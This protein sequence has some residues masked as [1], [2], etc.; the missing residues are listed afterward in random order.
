MTIR[1]F[2]NFYALPR[3]FSGFCRRYARSFISLDG[4]GTRDVPERDSSLLNSEGRPAI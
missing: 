2:R 1:G 4:V 3:R